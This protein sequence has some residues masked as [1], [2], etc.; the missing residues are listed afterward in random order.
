MTQLTTLS[1]TVRQRVDS[2][3]ISLLGAIYH[4]E[5]GTVEFLPPGR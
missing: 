5:N 3:Q 4:V 2:G 1:M